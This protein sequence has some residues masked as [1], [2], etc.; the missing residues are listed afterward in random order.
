MNLIDDRQL[1]DEQLSAA[2]PKLN[3]LA[4]SNAQS[5]CFAGMG[6]L[7]SKP[8]EKVKLIMAFSNWIIKES[9]CIIQI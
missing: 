9:H 6:T 2:R 3:V 4:N 1:A 7:P 5:I 8:I